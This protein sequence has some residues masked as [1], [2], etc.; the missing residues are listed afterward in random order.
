MENRCGCTSYLP[1]S[2]LDILA[3]RLPTSVPV[4]ST[5][6]GHGV[7]EWLSETKRTRFH[8]A[9]KV[10]YGRLVDES[11]VPSASLP[12]LQHIT[13]HLVFLLSLSIKMASWTCNANL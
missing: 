6:S 12:L 3:M 1:T 7:P 8:S 2:V 13:E 5:G 4:T 10:G 9:S 11:G